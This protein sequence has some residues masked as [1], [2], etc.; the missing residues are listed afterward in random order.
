MYTYR[1]LRYAT[2]WNRR[3]AFAVVILV[4]LTLSWRAYRGGQRAHPHA[5]ERLGQLV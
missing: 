2:R 1:R 3:A 5:A 4:L